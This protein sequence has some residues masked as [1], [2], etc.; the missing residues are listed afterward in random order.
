M[1]PYDLIVFDWDGTLVDSPA[2]IVECIQQA[3]RDLGLEARLTGFRAQA[4]SLSL[5]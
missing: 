5:V 2:A 3:S 1:K 4:Y